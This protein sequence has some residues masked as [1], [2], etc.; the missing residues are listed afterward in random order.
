MITTKSEIDVRYYIYIYIYTKL[1]V[2][3]LSHDT[4]FPSEVLAP[5]S[6]FCAR[7]AQ[8]GVPAPS[9]DFPHNFRTV[10]QSG[11]SMAA[12]MDLWGVFV[13]FI[14][15]VGSTW[16]RAPLWSSGQMPG[17]RSRG[18]GFDSRLYRICWEIL[19]LKLGPFSFV[20]IIEE[21]PE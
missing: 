9:S 10:I 14:F 16:V 5:F 6:L 19:V 3:L 20:G 13:V 2:L 11:L 21:L 8:C 7:T 1:V 17:Y 4:V 15:K 12:P 18:P